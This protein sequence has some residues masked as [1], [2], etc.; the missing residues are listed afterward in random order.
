MGRVCPGSCM[1]CCLSHKCKVTGAFSSSGTCISVGYDSPRMCG[2]RDNQRHLRQIGSPALAV[3]GVVTAI[4]YWAGQRLIANCCVMNAISNPSRALVS[5]RRWEMYQPSW[6]RARSQVIVCVSGAFSIGW[7]LLWQQLISG[8]RP[9]SLGCRWLRLRSR[10]PLSM[11][12]VVCSSTPIGWGIL[13]S[14]VIS[15]MLESVPSA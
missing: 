7:P 11:P 6:P 5:L 13:S 10:R 2:D 1:L 3:L 12:R 8:W 14:L 4:T 9:P 15:S